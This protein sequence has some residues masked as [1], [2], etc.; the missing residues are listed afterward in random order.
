M[1][2]SFS[3][4][5]A[6]VLVEHSLQIFRIFRFRQSQHEQNPRFVRHQAVALNKWIVPVDWD[7]ALA[8]AASEDYWNSVRGDFLDACELIGGGPAVE[9]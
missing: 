2:A 6:S 7:S 1:K 8:A 4:S 9:A 5:R 3:T